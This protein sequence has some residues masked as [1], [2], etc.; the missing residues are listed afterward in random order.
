[1]FEDCFARGK[2]ECT[3]LAV[4]MCKKGRCPFYK[5]QEQYRKDRI[6]YPTIH[7]RARKEAAED[8]G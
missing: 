8:N 5:S 4:M 7:E 2:S 6:K 1:M 3:L